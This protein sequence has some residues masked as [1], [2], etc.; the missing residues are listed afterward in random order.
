M[1]ISN[2]TATQLKQALSLLDKKEALQ[3]QIEEID[4]RVSSLFGGKAPVEGTTRRRRG[5]RPGRIHGA[6]DQ[7]RRKQHG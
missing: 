5:G 3:K 4:T 1:N 7:L 6:R 2:L